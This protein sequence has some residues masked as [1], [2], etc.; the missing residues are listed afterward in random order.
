MRKLLSF[1]FFLV[2]VVAI[3]VAY[4]ALVS[5]NINSGKKVSVKIPTGSSYA[6]VLAILKQNQVLKNEFTFSLVSEWKHYPTQVKS[7][8]YVFSA[9][10]NNRQ[11]INMLR[12]GW[13]T[14]V[15]LIFT[16]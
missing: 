14:P 12:L 4:I 11:I 7:G 13:Q 8:Y 6:D 2:I 1:I 3:G 16:T 5:P 10:M 15:T 9:G